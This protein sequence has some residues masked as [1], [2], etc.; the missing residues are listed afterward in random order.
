MKL[1]VLAFA[2]HPDDVELACSGTMA[3]LKAQGKKTGI[4]DLTRGEL[5]TRGTA[6]IRD[7]EAAASAKILG[8]DVR[9]NLRFR[10]GF[11]VND[12]AHQIP[13]IQMLRKY[14]PEIILI[15]APFDRHPD[16]GKGSSLVRDAAFLSGLRRISTTL[17]GEE[18]QPWRP[19]KVFKYIQDFYIDPSFV[20]D[21][22]DHW[23][24]KMAS[25]RAFA[26]QFHDPSSEE[27][28]TYISSP[29]FLRYVESRAME[30]GH[31]I[32]AEYGE[33]F[34]SETPVKVDD[35]FTLI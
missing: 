32:R 4:I 12:E 34:I 5:G 24:T 17:D 35:M 18:Q 30:F 3:K 27:P 13:V 2:A 22:S 19:Q 20:V 14:Q 15:N 6:E 7:Q 10:D 9:E 31:R 11:F 23:E 21:I 8:L 16:H 29:K 26:S 25:I 28:T 1:D 33:G